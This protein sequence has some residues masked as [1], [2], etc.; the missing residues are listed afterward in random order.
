MPEPEVSSENDYSEWSTR[1]YGRD[2]TI[3]GRMMA[4]VRRYIREGKPPGD[5]L[6][7]VICHELFLAIGHADDENREN[8]PAYC[9]FFHNHAPADCHGSEEKYKAWI[10]KHKVTS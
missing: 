9:A 10:A 5:F 6:R 7:A 1:I 4:G 3:S 2:H 8:L